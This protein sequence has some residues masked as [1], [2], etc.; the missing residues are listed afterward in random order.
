VNAANF[1]KTPANRSK[2]R[3]ATAENGHDANVS[4]DD[5]VSLALCGAWYYPIQEPLR[6]IS[7]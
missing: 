5:D 7:E 2:T 6:T 3:Q 4:A 1:T